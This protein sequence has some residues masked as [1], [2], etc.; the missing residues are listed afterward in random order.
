M[1]H[2]YPYI[3]ERINPAPGRR[4]VPPGYISKLPPPKPKPKPRKAAKSTKRK[5]GE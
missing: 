3:Q 4:P 2:S 5:A 1:T